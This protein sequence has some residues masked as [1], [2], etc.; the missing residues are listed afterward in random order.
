M[1]VL[2]VLYEMAAILTNPDKFEKLIYIFFQ[3]RNNVSLKA[4]FFRAKLIGYLTVV[5]SLTVVKR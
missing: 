4:F 1:Y 2:F 3:L 5:K